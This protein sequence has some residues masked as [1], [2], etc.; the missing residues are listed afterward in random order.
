MRKNIKNIIKTFLFLCA[1]SFVL[2][3]CETD[4]DQLG[5]QFFEGTSAQGEQVAYDI[6]T[7]NV[8]N[9]DTIRTDASKLTYA[10]LGAFNENQFGLQKSSFV[11][12]VRLSSYNPSFGTSPVIDSV[13]MEFKPLYASDTVTT[14][15]DENYTYSDEKIPAK[16]VVNTYPI[17]KYG[18]TNSTMTL[19]VYEVDDYL[20]SY[21][22]EVYSNKSVSY[23]TLLGEKNLTGTVSSVAITKDSDNSSLLS[24]DAAV[25]IPLDASFF[26]SKIMNK[27]GQA[28]LADAASFIRYFKGIRLSVKEN[29]G[30]IMR[31][32]P[33]DTKITI[34]Y[35]NTDSTTPATLELSMGA[36]SAKYNQIEYDRTGTP[37]ASL[38]STPNYTNG[39]AKIYAQGMGGPS[40]GVRIPAEK[41]AEIR[42]LYNQNKIGIISAKVRLYVD[43][44]VWNNT[45]AKPQTFTAA[46]YTPSTKT[47]DL[48]A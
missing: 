17:S 27:Q 4:A 10:T 16:K 36:G 25:R 35:K 32:T 14:S 28:E 24:R 22:D 23:S 9:N 20:G 3:S 45:Y 6:I 46:Y 8:S 44:S 37:L 42:T 7:Y 13:V 21:N 43:N 2:Y 18:K 1:G 33:N 41:I 38:S 26:Q 40:I 39:D 30:Y 19:Q 48:S 47:A 15:T 5:S 11:S 31:F 29:N 34:Y 12:Q